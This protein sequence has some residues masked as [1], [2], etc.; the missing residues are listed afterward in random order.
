MFLCFL[1]HFANSLSILSASRSTFTAAS[2][3]HV[4]KFAETTQEVLINRATDLPSHMRISHP[5]MSRFISFPRLEN[6]EVVGPGL[7]V[8][9]VSP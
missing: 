3:Q 1:F 2:L 9:D 5:Y 4:M 8:F 6:N 7:P